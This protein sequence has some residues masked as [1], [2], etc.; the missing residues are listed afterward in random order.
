VSS[1]PPAGPTAFDGSPIGPPHGYAPV[2][3]T[4]VAEPGLTR[5]GRR[6][7]A[8]PSP[9]AYWRG[10]PE[11]RADLRACTGLV[12]L[13]VAAGLVAGLVWW[14]LA[15]R[16]DFRI[17]DT[18]PVVIG[19]PSDELFVADDS[20][21]TL[22]LAGFGLVAGAA[23]WFLRHRRGV[24]VVLALAIGGTA[25]AAVAW[26][27]GELLGPAPTQ[28]QISDVGA[29]VTTGLELNSLPALAVAPFVALLV[30]V[31][32]VLCTAADDLG[33][34]DAQPAPSVPGEEHPLV[35][36]PGLPAS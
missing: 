22:V 12:L 30:Y 23:A 4:E 2:D 21:F 3:L 14:W 29:V 1:T 32:A 5:R 36:T 31:G 15:P 33:R 26:Q 34:T 35:A 19:D 18:G 24:A 7:K 11:I 6:A 16:A 10:W 28:A 13:L 9:S 20:V 25:M 8:A 17:T 27:L